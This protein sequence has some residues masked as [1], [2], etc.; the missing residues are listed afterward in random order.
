MLGFHVLALNKEEVKLN[1]QAMATFHENRAERTVVR[2]R[3]VVC[4][5]IEEL[6]HPRV[7]LKMGALGGV[8]CPYCG[9]HFVK[10]ERPPDPEALRF[11]LSLSGF[12]L[13]PDFKDLRSPLFPT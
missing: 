13:V 5:G 3:H 10:Q 6:S 4:S 12:G 7:Y 9:R 11:C 8:L 2:S 1:I